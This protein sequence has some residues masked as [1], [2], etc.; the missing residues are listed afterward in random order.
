[1]PVRQDAQVA[2]ITEK[3][4]A[5]EDQAIMDIGFASRSFYI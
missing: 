2:E 1:M 5:A 4:E 3:E